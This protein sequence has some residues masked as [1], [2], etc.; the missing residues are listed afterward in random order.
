MTSTLKRKKKLC[1]KKQKQ[2]VTNISCGLPSLLDLG[3]APCLKAETGFCYAEI[4]SKKKSEQYSS[5]II[6]AH[7]K[8]SET[9]RNITLRIYSDETVG[10]GVSRYIHIGRSTLLCFEQ[11]VHFQGTT[12]A[13][14]KWNSSLTQC[15]KMSP[16]P[17]CYLFCLTGVKK[18]VFTYQFLVWSCDP[19]APV[20]LGQ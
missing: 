3:S 5:D 2:T 13:Q 15:L 18:D 12:W 11:K 20:P 1:P 4:S 6:K 16:H 19:T 7:S 17:S 8:P 10:R 14:L 9:S